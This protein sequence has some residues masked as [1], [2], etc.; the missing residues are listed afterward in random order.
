[1]ILFRYFS[2]AIF[3]PIAPTFS[4]FNATHGHKYFCPLLIGLHKKKII[5]QIVFTLLAF[6]LIANVLKVISGL[7]VSPIFHKNQFHI[8]TH[9]MIMTR[10]EMLNSNHVFFVVSSK[11]KP[12]S[13][14]LILFMCYHLFMFGLNRIYMINHKVH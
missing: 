3:V 12:S 13:I 4:L 7:F 9:D 5:D 8:H 14:E 10:I 2:A 1:M 11:L 6:D